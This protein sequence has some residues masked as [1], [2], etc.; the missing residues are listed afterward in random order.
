MWTANTG[1]LVLAE[2]NDRLSGF[3]MSDGHLAWQTRI[4]RLS[5][6]F[7]PRLNDKAIIVVAEGEE[8]EPRRYQIVAIAPESGR[9]L[10]GDLVT[11]PLN[12]LS[13]IHLRDR[14]IILSTD[15]Q[16]IGYGPD[17]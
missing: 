5:H 16:L 4:P 7:A 12:S 15:Q 6:V 3:C 2:A 13:E 10:N 17:H 8:G 11:E 9:R 14:C 1:G